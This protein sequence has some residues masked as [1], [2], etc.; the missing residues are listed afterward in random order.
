MA[1]RRFHLIVFVGS[2][3][4]TLL[5]TA[6]VSLIWPRK[7]TPIVKLK[8]GYDFRFY[9]TNDKTL[10]EPAIGSKIN[11]GNFRTSKGEK[12]SD[13]LNQGLLLFVVV[14]P[15]CPACD[16]MM[17]EKMYTDLSL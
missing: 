7:E 17:L 1:K 16:L 10:F 15:L 4:L 14:D 2:F 8:Q 3:I 6:I 13:G 5:L 11:L 12:V 9:R